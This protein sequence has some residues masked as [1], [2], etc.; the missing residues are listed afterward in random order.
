VATRSAGNI[1]AQHGSHWN[2]YLPKTAVSPSISNVERLMTMM[3]EK[4]VPD[5]G[6]QRLQWQRPATIGAAEIL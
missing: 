5:C 3:V 6:R 2:R 1:G 4:A